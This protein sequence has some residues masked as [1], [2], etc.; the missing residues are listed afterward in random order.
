MASLTSVVATLKREEQK[1]VKQLGR[2]QVRLQSL[3][4]RRSYIRRKLNSTPEAQTP[5]CGF[6]RSSKTVRTKRAWSAK[7][8]KAVSTRMKRYWAAKRAQ[9]K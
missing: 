7:A 4:I 8:R 9:K 6:Y 2:I 3:R 1:L 5:V